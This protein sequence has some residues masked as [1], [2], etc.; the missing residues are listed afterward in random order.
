MSGGPS[1]LERWPGKP[2]AEIRAAYDESEAEKLEG[3]HWLKRRLGGYARGRQFGDAHGRVLDVACGTGPNFR[4][5]PE[6][7]HL[8]GIDLSADMLDYADETAAALDRRVELKQMDAQ[9]LSFEDDTFD[10]V[11]SSFSTCT[12]PDPLE[13]LDEMGRVCKPGGRIRLLEHHQWQFAPLA[14]LQERGADDE[15]HR[16]GCRLYDDPAAVVEGSSLEVV[17]TD[18][19]RFPPFTG[20]VA[21]PS[22]GLTQRT[23]LR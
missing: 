18:R 23:S 16:V 15:Y 12:F 19:W 6:G 11:V 9:R 10:T 13:A 20:V 2:V 5:V 7:A 3:L 14:W 22:G 17:D 4:H 21:R 1:E 8:V